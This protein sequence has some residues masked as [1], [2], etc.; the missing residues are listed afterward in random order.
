MAHCNA[1][2]GM[3]SAKYAECIEKSFHDRCLEK[4]PKRLATKK[5][6]KKSKKKGPTKLAAKKYPLFPK[7]ALLDAIPQY[8][9]DRPPDCEETTETWGNNV[10]GGIT[11][12]DC[13]GCFY[14]ESWTATEITITVGCCDEVPNS[15]AMDCE[16]TSET[17][18]RPSS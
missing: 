17:K 10:E 14:E 11:H 15:T 8:L 5:T 16:S 7:N 6:K 9:T 2:V 3:R 12:T 13:E 18:P 4:K 1:K